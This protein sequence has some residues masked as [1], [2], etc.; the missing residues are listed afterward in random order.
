MS[1]VTEGFTLFCS[2]CKCLMF[3]FSRR[4]GVQDENSPLKVS[5]E[6]IPTLKKVKYKEFSNKSLFLRVFLFSSQNINNYIPFNL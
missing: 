6:N 1:F 2:V 3:H 4:K 5:H